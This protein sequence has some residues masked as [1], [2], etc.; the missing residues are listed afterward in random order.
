[1]NTSRTQ[2][3]FELPKPFFIFVV[4][5]INMP[6]EGLPSSSE[7]MVNTL[8]KEKSLSSFRTEGRSSNTVMVLRLSA[9]TAQ[10][11]AT[12]PPAPPFGTSVRH[13]L[14][15]TGEGQRRTKIKSRT[16]RQGIMQ[17]SHHLVHF[18]QPRPVYLMKST[19][20]LLNLCHTDNKTWT[21]HHT[22]SLT[23]HVKH[24]KSC[25][26]INR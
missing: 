19:T 23:V 16:K 14:T 4:I 11:S 8:L 7:N 5:S 6:V 20:A 1:M 17:S 22:S 12:S 26:N 18:F 3:I 10:H 9:R 15:E 13:K 25:R 21:T 24:E 2:H